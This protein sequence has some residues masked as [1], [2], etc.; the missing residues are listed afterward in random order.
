[1]T[2]NRILPAAVFLGALIV[3]FLALPARDSLGRPLPVAL[4]LGAA[5]GIVLQRSR[6]CFW[7]NAADWFRDRNP[8]GLIAILAALA[9][10]AVGHW[11]IA[12]AWLPDPSTGRLP[13][14]A[15]IGPV[16]LTL[17]AGA[18]VFGLGMAVSGSC[19][20]AHFYRLGEGAYGS[21]IALAGAAVG[22]VLGFLSWN[23]LWLNDVISARVIWLPTF[24]GHDGALV[25]T[26][27]LIGALWLILRQRGA[28]A[29]TPAG[30]WPGVLGGVLVGFIATLAWFRIG[31]L[32]VTAELGSL[33]RTAAVDLGLLPDTLL[34]LDGLRGCATVVKETLLSRN[35]VF[36]LGLVLGAA[37]AAHAAGDW[38]PAFPA[39]RDVPRLFLGG[40]MLGWGAMVALGCT[41]GVI[42]SGIMVGALSGWVFAVAC[43][44]GAWTGWRLRAVRQSV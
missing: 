14:D 33:S 7:C 10:G 6:F 19:I 38:K 15:H 9:A 21:V 39:V 41:V 23:W 2:F 24:L 28:G 27:T 1:M 40:V 12:G 11:V 29:S 44:A 32:G 5:F 37:A 36:V 16:S 18:F 42:L 4:A 20:S 30:R 25:L 34:G 43:L 22:F 31:P 13:P 3:L 8:S 17:A 35:G 26:L